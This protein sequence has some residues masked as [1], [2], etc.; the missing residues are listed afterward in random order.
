[1]KQNKKKSIQSDGTNRSVSRSQTHSDHV[2][3]V[4]MSS[5]K[6]LHMCGLKQLMNQRRRSLSLQQSNNIIS[7]FNYLYWHYVKY[8]SWL[9][10]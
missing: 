9:I 10:N 1:M 5:Q 8:I 2:A 3:D 7:M 4:D 6:L